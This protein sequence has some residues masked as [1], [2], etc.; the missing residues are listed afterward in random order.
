MMNADTRQEG[1]EPMRLLPATQRRW[2]VLAVCVLVA[3]P[4]AYAAV[5]GALG[6]KA[7]PAASGVVDYGFTRRSAPAPAFELPLL[8]H[9]GD[10]RLSSLAGRPIVLNFWASTCDICRQ[11]S[12]AIAAVSRTMGGRVRFLG[13]DTGDEAAA[14]MQF[15]RRYDIRY[16]VVFDGN[17][18]VAAQYGVPGLP[19]TVFLSPTAKRILGVNLGALTV[20]GLT[21]ILHRL[22]GTTA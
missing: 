5:S 15:I 8:Q 21:S 9:R 3:L 1:A 11:E 7:S 13:V 10:V 20:A 16:Q 14:A 6:G 18:V 2:L 4:V 12:P 19:V 22:Y 17:G